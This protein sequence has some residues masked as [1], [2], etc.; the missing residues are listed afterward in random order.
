MRKLP[1]G[2]QTVDMDQRENKVERFSVAVA[3]AGHRESHPGND[4][5]LFALSAILYGA[6]GA[7]TIG[8]SMQ[9]LTDPVNSI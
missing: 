7:F 1:F 8:A 2:R 5:L 6:R 9:H 3:S 4:G